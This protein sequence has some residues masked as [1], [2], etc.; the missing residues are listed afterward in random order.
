MLLTPVHAE[1]IRR[2]DYWAAIPWLLHNQ[3]PCRQLFQLIIFYLPTSFGTIRTKN[4]RIDEV[5]NRGK[6]EHHS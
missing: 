2:K 1:L 4:I 6:N 3:P 5:E